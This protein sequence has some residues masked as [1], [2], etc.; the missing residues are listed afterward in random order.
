MDAA[1]AS[2][3]R[4]VRSLCASR[5]RRSVRS[6]QERSTLFIRCPGDP[7][8]S[9]G[10]SCTKDIVEVPEKV[11]KR[12]VKGGGEET[13]HAVELPEQKHGGEQKHG[14]SCAAM[15]HALPDGAAPKYGDGERENE[16]E[17]AVVTRTNH[18]PAQGRAVVLLRKMAHAVRVF[19]KGVE[20]GDGGGASRV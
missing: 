11:L 4:A 20:I 5:K 1:L 19:Q 18:E 2:R 8:E 3:A 13:R 16:Q 10:K 6:A 7:K 9:D 14:A 12:H 17:E 15:Q